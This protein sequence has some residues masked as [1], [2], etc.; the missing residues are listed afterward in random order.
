VNKGSK[1]KHPLPKRF[2]RMASRIPS[3]S[4]LVLR[5]SIGASRLI[6][7]PCL[8]NGVSTG[9]GHRQ[10]HRILFLAKERKPLVYE[11]SKVINRQ[12]YLVQRP[13]SDLFLKHHA[14]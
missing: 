13:R 9:P 12:A 14:C 5:S 1:K 11:L 4:S 2:S 3:S 10:L 7:V 6:L 8:V